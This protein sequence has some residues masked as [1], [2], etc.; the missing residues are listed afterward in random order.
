MLH[1]AQKDFGKENEVILR[2]SV[3]HAWLNA[4]DPWVTAWHRTH[5]D[6]KDWALKCSICGTCILQLPQYLSEKDKEL[7]IMVMIMTAISLF[8]IDIGIAINLINMLLYIYNIS[9]STLIT[10]LINKISNA[11]Y[12]PTLRPALLDHPVEWPW[13]LLVIPV[14]P[15]PRSVRNHWGQG[16]CVRIRVRKRCAHRN[17]SLKAKSPFE[18]SAHRDPKHPFFHSFGI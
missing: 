13:P 12:H 1:K 6:W 15:L 5:D 11:I 9:Y 17:T 4:G 2:T 10:L 18:D 3:L 14:F 7:Y 8:S 16:C